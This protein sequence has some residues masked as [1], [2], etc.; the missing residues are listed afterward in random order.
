MSDCF[1]GQSL[2]YLTPRGF[3]LVLE[4][5]MFPSVCDQAMVLQLSVILK[6]K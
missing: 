1:F 2:T 3:L 6:N 4:Q 5:V